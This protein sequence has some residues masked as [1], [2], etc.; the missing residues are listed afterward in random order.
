MRHT[1]AIKLLDAKLHIL[2]ANQRKDPQGEEAK[3]R[4]LLMAEL[5]VSRAR[6]MKDEAHG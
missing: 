6:L 5:E 1:E 2:R 3:R 4:E